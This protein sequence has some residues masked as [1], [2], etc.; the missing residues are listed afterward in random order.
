MSIYKIIGSNLK[1]LRKERG[2][3]Q[4]D[5]ANFLGVSHVAVSKWESGQNK[6]DID[7]LEAIADLFK[8]RVNELV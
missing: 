5:I 1:R 7:V 3:R 6:I 2:L 4:R 8:V